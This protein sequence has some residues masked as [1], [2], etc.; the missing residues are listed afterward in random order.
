MC[1]PRV[2]VNDVIKLLFEILVHTQ[3]ECMGRLVTVNLYSLCKLDNF[4]RI[5]VLSLTSFPRP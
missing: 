4:G 1:S 5:V 3:Y 2:T